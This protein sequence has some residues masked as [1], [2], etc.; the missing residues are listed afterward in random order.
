MS[1][2]KVRNFFTQ[3]I[4]TTTDGLGLYVLNRN[5]DEVLNK[6]FR[7]WFIFVYG[8]IVG[9]V[10]VLLQVAFQI[11]VGFFQLTREI[12]MNMIIFPF[13]I[14]VFASVL[15]TLSARGLGGKGNFRPLVNYIFYANTFHLVIPFFDL[16]FN[17]ILG[18]PFVFDFGIWGEWNPLNPWHSLFYDKLV[19]LSAGIIFM[20]VLLIIRTPSMVRW[21]FKI[22]LKRSILATSSLLLMFWIIFIAWPF[23]FFWLSPFLGLPTGADGYSLIFLVCTLIA[24]PYFWKYFKQEENLALNSIELQGG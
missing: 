9:S 17:K 21:N 16:F 4:Q 3:I 2:K 7:L 10:R 5:R 1:W 13:F 18:L 15:L 22:N 8:A 19:G 23:W 24:F 11:V 12:F 20:Y 14:T 6:K